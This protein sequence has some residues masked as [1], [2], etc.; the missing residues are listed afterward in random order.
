MMTQ[1]S[2]E[3]ILLTVRYKPSWKTAKKLLEM[4][5]SYFFLCTPPQVK[6]IGIFGVCCSLSPLC[7]SMSLTSSQVK[8]AVDHHNV[9]RR[10]PRTQILTFSSTPSGKT[11]QGPLSLHV[12]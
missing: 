10:F 12:T 1:I 9:S 3:C 4:L 11:R 7:P 2:P 5:N 8:P 6:D